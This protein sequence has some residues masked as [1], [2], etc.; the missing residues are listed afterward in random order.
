MRILVTKQ[1][2]IIIQDLESLPQALNTIPNFSNNLYR[3]NSTN[4]IKKSKNYF[5]NISSPTKKKNKFFSPEK[6]YNRPLFAQTV[7]QKFKI[8]KN[9]EDIEFTPVEIENAKQIRL[10]TRKI[11]FPKNFAEQYERDNIKSKLANKSI[12]PSLS[13]KQQE[14][15][16][17]SNIN[18]L[19]EKYLS[20]EDIIPINNV[21]RMKQKILNDIKSKEKNYIFTEDNFRTQYIQE[22]DIQKFNHVLSCGKLNTNY[23]SLIKYLHEKKLNPLTVKNIS[24]SDSSKISKMNKMCQIFYQNEDK[25]KLFNDHVKNKIKQHINGTKREFQAEINDLGKDINKIKEKLNKY[26]KLIDDREKYKEY[27]NDVV[28]NHWRKRDYERLNKKSTPKSKYLNTF[29]DGE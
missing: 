8:R 28:V 19:K 6:S 16:N 24:I 4:H 2:N 27:F 22:S 20:F 14:T 26:N 15:N 29:S 23:S 11:T 1:G 17:G 7:T 9:V 5:N 12:L 21:K 3:G 13:S 10:S 18:I 25:N